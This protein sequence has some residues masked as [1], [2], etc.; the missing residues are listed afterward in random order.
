MRL[1]PDREPVATPDIGTAR[2]AAGGVSVP[3][4]VRWSIP[5]TRLPIGEGV[6]RVA[7]QVQ[8][9]SISVLAGHI[10]FRLM[11]A[12]FPTLI[13][14]LWLLRVINADGIVSRVS[15]LVSAIV[16][17]VAHAP[18]EQQIEGAPRPQA[19]GDFTLGVGASFL[20]AVW[21]ISEVFRAAMHALNVVYGVTERRSRVRRVV[22]SVGVSLVTMTLFVGA[23]LLIVSGARVA[24]TLTE[25]SGFG[26]SYEF[27][28]WA[29]AWVVVVSSVLVAFA[30]TYYY[31]PDVEQRIRWV[32]TGSLAGVVLWLAFAGLFAVYVNVLSRPGDTYGALAGVALFMVYLYGSAFILLLGAEFNQVIENWEPDGKSS[33]ERAPDA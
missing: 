14:V 20:V 6:R 9:D 31:A 8:A 1:P 33:G 32:R 18:L 19:S 25:W 13:S 26:V 10:A 11:F 30:L 28:W 7:H 22:T 23:L 16:P 24:A 5:G 12:L 17:G 3:G 29:S 4:L 27:V 15:E 2:A 21:A